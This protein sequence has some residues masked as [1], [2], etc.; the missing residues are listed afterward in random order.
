MLFRSDLSK[1]DPSGFISPYTFTVSSLTLLFP[2][3]SILLTTSALE[4]LAR[5]KKNQT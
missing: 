2:L 1:S 3:I 5:K 4:I